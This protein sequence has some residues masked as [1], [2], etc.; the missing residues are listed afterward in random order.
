M[1]KLNEQ[2]FKQ[3]IVATFISGSWIKFLNLSFLVQSLTLGH[4]LGKV[5]LY[6]VDKVLLKLH[7]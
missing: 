4:Y 1:N 3:K 2:L 5:A 7:L 6:Q